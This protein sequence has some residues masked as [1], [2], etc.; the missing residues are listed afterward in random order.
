MTVGSKHQHSYTCHF[1]SIICAQLAVQP[2]GLPSKPAAW[3]V[4][5]DFEAV[6]PTLR[7]WRGQLMGSWYMQILSYGYNG[8]LNK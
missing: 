3:D 2:V 6:I 4:I 5:L 7:L 1:N 8:K